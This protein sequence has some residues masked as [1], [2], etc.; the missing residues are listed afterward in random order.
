MLMPTAAQLQAAVTWAL[1]QT[2]ADSAGAQQPITANT[3]AQ[4]VNAVREYLNTNGIKYETF[5]FPILAPYLP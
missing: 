5:D 3:P 2:Y 4:L 1:S